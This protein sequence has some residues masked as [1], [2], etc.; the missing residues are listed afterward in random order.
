MHIV[1][2][3]I[4]QLGRSFLIAS[5][6]VAALAGAA[7][8]AE[9]TA[10]VSAGV[11]V[12]DN[13]ARTDSDQINETFNL[14][15]AQFQLTE[16]TQSIDA[17]IQANIDYLQYQDN[18]FSDQ[19]VGGV[20]ASIDWTVVDQRINWIVEETFGQQLLN[21]LAPLS[22][23]NRENINFFSTGPDF[24][25]PVGARNSLG[26]NL[27]YTNINYERRQFDNDRSSATVFVRRAIRENANLSLNAFAEKTKFDAGVIAPDFDRYEG[28]VRFD[29]L[30]ARNTFGVDAGYTGLDI[31]GQRRNGM[32]LRVDWTRTISPFTSF[33]LG[34]GSRYSDQG[35][36][37][38][39]SQSRANNLADVNDIGTLGVPFLNN[40]FNA[41]YV[42]NRERTTAAI[43]FSWNQEDYKEGGN[44]D[45][46]IWRVDGNLS[47]DITANIFTRLSFRFDIRDYK[48]LIRR[49]DSLRGQVTLGYRFNAAFSLSLSYQYA[50]RKSDASRADY[51]EN[52]GVIRFSYY[53]DWGR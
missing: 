13:I 18:T 49:D 27:R 48:Y 23:R 34:G 33:T 31:N 39:I 36:I 11:G 17:Q 52:R 20:D 50:Q 32:L 45:R 12:S 22:P 37:F 4:R 28:Y 7:M 16:L 53:P 21:P 8:A 3:Q 41:N 1:E 30:S 43:N 44:L 9:I 46:D 10:N 47:R 14:V 19:V 38:N 42:I 15:G 25:I 26:A 6:C 51:K 29:V 24:L 35:N 40:F 5:L 2:E